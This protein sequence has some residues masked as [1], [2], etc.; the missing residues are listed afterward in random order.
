M[1]RVTH[2][3][4]GEWKSVDC[5]DLQSALGV[6]KELLRDHIEMVNVMPL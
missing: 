6:I 5:I 1:F 2:Y 3:Y 4:R